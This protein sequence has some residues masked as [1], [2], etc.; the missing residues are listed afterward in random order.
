MP[1]TL[2]KALKLGATAL[3]PAMILQGAASAADDFEIVEYRVESDDCVGCGGQYFESPDEARVYL[4][5]VRS[6]LA[7][8]HG[9]FFG[10]FFRR[11]EPQVVFLDFDAGGAPT[12]PVCTIDAAGNPTGVFGIFNDHFYTPEERDEIQARIEA[13]YEK[14]NFEFVQSPPPAGTDFTTIAFGQNDA[15]EDCS[16]GSNISITATGGVSILFG[17]A[18]GIDFRNQNRNDNAFADASFW[19]FLAQFDPTGGTFSALSGLNLAD[20][21]G[22]LVLAVSEAVTNQ[23]SNTGAHEAGHI[24]GLRHQ[25]SFGAPGDG[26]PDTGAI[27]PNAFVPVFGG[28]SNASE[29]VLHTMASGASV[30]LGLTGSTITDRFFSERSATRLAINERGSV[31]TEDSINNRRFSF[32]NGL[33]SLRWIFV[34]NTIVEGQNADALLRVRARVIEGNI[35]VEGEKDSYK[36]FGIKGEFFNAELISVIGEQLTFEE[37]ILGQVRLFQLNYDGTETLVAS[38]LQSFESLFDAEIFD[39]VLPKTGFYRVEVSAPDEFFPVDLDGDG[40]LDP[41][42][43]STAGGAPEL[44]TGAYSLQVYTCVKKLNPFRRNHFVIASADDDDDD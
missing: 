16:Q 3:A 40:V 7:A 12:F 36:F 28:P 21:G 37:G 31:T 35:D 32:L 8:K 2:G 14:F 41:L 42:P 22:N 18:E 27:P 5:G 13:D 11:G 25:N 23:S 43:I 15:P 26:L 44:L 1:I 9:G 20:F 19:E 17:Q 38:N 4:D 39:A 29:T 10:S 34:P 30:G 6:F 24:L 33:F